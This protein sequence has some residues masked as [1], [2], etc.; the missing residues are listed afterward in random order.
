M[1]PLFELLQEHEDCDFEAKAAQGRD[2]RGE[3]PR[4]IWSSYSAMA[5]TQGGIILLGAEED[6]AGNL[7]ATG[8]Q[9]T[10][11]IRKSFWDNI[12]N[13]EIVNANLL[14]DKDVSEIEHEGARLLCLHVPRATRVQRPVYTGSNPL[15][16]TYRRNYEGDYKCDVETV[17]RM[18]AEA[19]EEIRDA[20]IL[21]GFGLDDLNA[22]SLKAYRNEMKSTKPNHPY[23]AF[24]DLEFLRNIGGW[25]KD[26]QTDA[27]GLT[28]AGLLMFGRLASILDA[29][30]HYVVD[31]QERPL[32]AS[33]M[34][35]TDRVTTDGTWSG[36]LF[37]FF[38]RV[39]P[40]LTADLKVPFRLQQNS[41]RV[42][43]SH[44]HEA[45]RE[46]LV[47]TLI[48]ADFTDRIPILVVKRQDLFGF[49]NP[50]G[51]RL[52]VDV[53]LQ[54]G[55][56]DCRNRRLQ[57]MFQLIGAAEQAGSG[58][59]KILRAWK[60]QHWR[61]PLLDEKY[62]PEQTVLRLP[63]TSLLPPEAIEELDKRFGPK[64]RD[65]G[66]VERLA[67]VTALIEEKV[68]NQRLRVM[69]ATHTSD[70][71]AIFKTLVGSGFLARDGVG[72][73]TCYRLPGQTR[74][75][76]ERLTAATSL[77]G[78]EESDI[79]AASDSEHSAPNSE[80][81]PSNSE[82]TPSNSEHSAPNSEQTPSN[83]EH[84]APNSEHSAPNSEHLISI[85]APV[86]STK[87]APADLVRTTILQLCADDFRSLQTLA[88][89]LGRKPASLRIRH[90]NA[91]IKNGQL[92]YQF[93]DRINHP[94]QG[95]RTVRT[96]VEKR[97]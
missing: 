30:P 74:A 15:T 31:Y 67:V 90:I 13:R 12:N 45:L 9:N 89:L 69:T 54:G 78:S 61:Y 10:A 38:R 57:K 88:N 70:V 95:Y 26:R 46:A 58:Y 63:T 91:L 84:S 48:H 19:I 80:Q 36:N 4:A 73:A 16:G 6:E 3:V 42:D 75:E 77:F 82:Q 39:Y 32:P 34:R 5:N 85:A 64:F 25:S 71:T 47:N 41:K 62:Q 1:K 72:W 22:D 7:L 56:S 86:R 51:L 35:W 68:T 28:L 17:R 44:V 18:L 92:E 43:E 50:G 14:Q 8:L 11:K 37:D 87:N 20:R 60:E 2:G 52:P 96:G 23:L 40:R 55:Q 53:I 76:K 59:P 79:S 94:G 21:S 97:T 83:S 93:P 49:R 81:T 66:E 27:A 65:L 24:D 29:V 33:E